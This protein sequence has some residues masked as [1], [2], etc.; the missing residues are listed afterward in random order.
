MDISK[1]ALS[2]VILG[3]FL[4]IYNILK[5]C[6]TICTLFRRTFI[7]PLLSEQAVNVSHG[8]LNLKY[9]KKNSFIF[10]KNEMFTL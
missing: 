10:H 9:Q 3:E 8:A 1:I 7:T 2:F 5:L 4:H 6:T